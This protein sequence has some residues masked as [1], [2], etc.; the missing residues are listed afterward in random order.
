MRTLEDLQ[1]LNG[2]PVDRQIL[3]EQ[4]YDESDIGEDEHEFSQHSNSNA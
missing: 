3:E 1:Y 4:D 2:L